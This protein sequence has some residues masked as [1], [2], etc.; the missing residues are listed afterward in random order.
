MAAFDN[1][2]QTPGGDLFGDLYN[3]YNDTVTALKD[4]Q[5]GFVLTSLGIGTAPEMKHPSLLFKEF[6]IGDWNMDTTR[7]KTYLWS[8]LG[9]NPAKVRFVSVW[10][11]NDNDTSYLNMTPLDAVQ[12]FVGGDF[13]GGAPGPQGGVDY[14]MVVFAP[15]ALVISRRDSGFYDSVNYDSTSFNRGYITIGV[16][17]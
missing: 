15:Q 6:N 4:G 16:V 1:L 7:S 14:A 5:N 3:K 17:A 9:I 11:R 8:D 13:T 2:N 10:I 12:N